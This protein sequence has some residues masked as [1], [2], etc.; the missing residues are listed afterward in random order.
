M[1]PIEFKGCNVVFAKHQPQYLSLPAHRSADGMITSC[2]QMTGWEKLKVFFSGK[3]WLTILVF[4]SPLQPQRLSVSS[5][6]VKVK[7]GS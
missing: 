2:W 7:S 3:I 1:R 6:I 4:N 5:P